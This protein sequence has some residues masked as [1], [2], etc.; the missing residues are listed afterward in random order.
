[1][2]IECPT[3]KL[4]GEVN[5]AEIP[6]DGRYIDCPRCKNGFH[7]K[8]PLAKGWNQNMM[9]SCPACQ[10]ST[11]TDE[12]F[13]V[14]P[15]CG[16]QGKVHNE[17]KLKQQEEAQL[18][19]DAERLTRSLRPDDFISPPLKEIEPEISSVPPVVRYTAAG[20]LAVA[21]LVAFSGVTGLIGYNGDTLFEK[22]NE[23]SIEP[24]SRTKIFLAHGLL[25]WVLTIYGVMM[26]F[27]SGMLLRSGRGALRLL[28]LGA[29]IGMGIGVAYEVID[30]I[31][32]VRRSSASASFEY[33]LVGFVTSAL[34]LAVW[35]VL[36]VALVRWIRSERF[37][38]ESDGG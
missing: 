7:V 18:K 13:D 16:L 19:K 34:L 22:I 38:R 27:F 17:R 29:F 33:Y 12:M 37:R 14:C 9:S 21:C 10:Y 3:C 8:K 31:A 35:V 25:P 5:E 32:V 20:V 15:K 23:T 24:V 28:E 30:F 36:P 11:F 1:M 26:A 6:L 2:K 4:S